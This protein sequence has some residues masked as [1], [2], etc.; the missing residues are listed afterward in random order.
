MDTKQ[1]PGISIEQI[2]LAES[3]FRRESEVPADMQAHVDINVGFGFPE[4]RDRVF[5]EM[6]AT[7]N[8]PAAP[9]YA[10]VKYIGIFSGARAADPALETYARA[11]A[12]ATLLP[13][14]RHEIH[15]M[16]RKAGLPQVFIPLF[17]VVMA[18]KKT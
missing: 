3:E 2:V 17:D 12:P 9:V 1:Q 8:S 13:Y 11:G 7:L 10:R 14:V 5:V 18:G 15:E 4:E 16:T 6:T